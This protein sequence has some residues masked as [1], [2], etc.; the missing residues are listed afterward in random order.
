MF[1]STREFFCCEIS[2]FFYLDSQSVW[3][4][5]SCACIAS[6]FASVSTYT[7]VNEPNC[8]WFCQ[9][10][11]IRIQSSRHF[12]ILILFFFLVFFFT[13]RITRASQHPLRP[14]SRHQKAPRVY[15]QCLHQSPQLRPGPLRGRECP[16]RDQQSALLA[17]RQ[18][19]ELAPRQRGHRQRR[20]ARETRLLRHFLKLS[21]LSLQKSRIYLPSLSLSRSS[22]GK[23]NLGANHVLSWNPWRAADL[24]T[25]QWR[26]LALCNVSKNR[27]KWMIVEIRTSSLC[28]CVIL[29]AFLF[30]SS[31][32]SILLSRIYYLYIM[33]PILRNR[34]FLCTYMV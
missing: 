18:C 28:F 7:K 30:S 15:A 16:P 4:C 34:H 32:R 23:K 29:F 17:C 13:S 10:E 33:E 19:R 14:Q 26:F 3:N 1:W 5:L 9:S 20:R 22:R 8:N 24:E 6:I 31:V 11:P 27:K 21:S 25:S 2:V 12:M